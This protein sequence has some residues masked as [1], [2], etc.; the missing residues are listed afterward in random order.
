MQH[1]HPSKRRAFSLIEVLIAVVVLAFGM[2]GLA[3][4]F[5]AVVKQQT[6][7]KDSVQGVSVLRSAESWILGNVK[8]NEHQTVTNPS[9]LLGPTDRANRLDL[10]ENRRGWE[11]LVADTTWNVVNPEST[12]ADELVLPVL[13][14]SST[15]GLI[16]EK[17][18]GDI[19]IGRPVKNG[20]VVERG[21][22][23]PLAQRLY[24]SPYSS[25]N[26]KPEY[27]WDL[28]V[29]RVD[30]GLPHSLMPTSLVPAEV[31]RLKRNKYE[32]DAVEVVIFVRRIDPGIRFPRN[33]SPSL[34]YALADALLLPT[35][36]GSPSRLAISER[37]DGTPR[38]DGFGKN[39]G[40]Q[41]S[42]PK[43]LL[44]RFP[45][46]NLLDAITLST[47]STETQSPSV[48]LAA[49]QQVGQS[50]VD[51]LGTVHRVREYQTRDPSTNAAWPQP[52]LI[53]EPPFD[54]RVWQWAAAGSSDSPQVVFTT[55][56]PAAVGVVRIDPR[57]GGRL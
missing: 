12:W 18:S 53:V 26:A 48:L 19:A 57:K 15:A 42:A 2:L 41:Y 24:P 47:T 13:F 20:P 10:A 11:T 32:D 56:I 6:T 37:P 50:L 14:N 43:R 40:G 46:P 38:L 7:A 1:S 45:D 44:V 39:D 55:Q 31:D 25:L 9:S 4:V 51:T 27:V 34:A 8:L 23:I 3:A 35:A 54:I 5:P 16:Y 28:V 33:G 21:V 49:A 17:W 22:V 29:R 36:D 52:R 30:A